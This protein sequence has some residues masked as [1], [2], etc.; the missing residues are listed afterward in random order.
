MN[1]EFS[2][3]EKFTAWI[4]KRHSACCE[5]GSNN[6]THLKEIHTFVCKDCGLREWYAVRV[7]DSGIKFQIEDMEKKRLSGAKKG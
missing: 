2:E 5:C 3:Y 4:E 1:K 6:M 7:G